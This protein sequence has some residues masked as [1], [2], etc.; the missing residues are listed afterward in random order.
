MSQG[1]S[2]GQSDNGFFVRDTDGTRV[3]RV[4][5]RESDAEQDLARLAARAER[6]HRTEHRPCLCCGRRFLSQGPFNRLCGECGSAGGPPELDRV[7][8]TR[9]RGRVGWGVSAHG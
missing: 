6:A 5:R 3:S 9:A 2:I 8:T 7:T 1:F 4:F